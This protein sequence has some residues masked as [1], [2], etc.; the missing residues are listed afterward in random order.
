MNVPE[1]ERLGLENL[2]GG[3]AIERFN[4]ELARVLENVN[5]INTEATAAREIVN[6]QDCPI[7]RSHDQPLQ[8][9]GHRD[10]VDAWQQLVD[11]GQGTL[12]LAPILLGE[13]RKVAAE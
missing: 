13:N 8:Q 1:E 12:S 6:R 10:A 3:A 9:F 7:I 11:D 2:M 5:D 4:H